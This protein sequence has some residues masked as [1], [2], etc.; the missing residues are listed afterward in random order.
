MALIR[1]DQIPRLPP[2]KAGR[3]R[4]KRAAS[5]DERLSVAI[6]VYWLREGGSPIKEAIETVA[7]RRGLGWATVARIFY[8]TKPETLRTIAAGWRH[9]ADEGPALRELIEEIPELLAVANEI[10]GD[11]AGRWA[12]ELAAARL[13]ERGAVIVKI[14]RILIKK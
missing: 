9:L 14:R 5:L 12:R 4:P 3:G 7:K 8:G 6:A 11:V 13:S 10:P 1:R 2:I